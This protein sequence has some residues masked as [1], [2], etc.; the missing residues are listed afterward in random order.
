MMAKAGAPTSAVTT[1]IGKTEPVMMVRATTSQTTANS[2]EPV[3]DWLVH[4]I[5]AE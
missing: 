2:L 4:W 3:Y 5:S 1:P